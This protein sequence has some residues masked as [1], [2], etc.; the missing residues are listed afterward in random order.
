MSLTSWFLSIEDCQNTQLF[1][2]WITAP[3][4][5]RL[6]LNPASQEGKPYDWQPSRPAWSSIGSVLGETGHEAESV[7]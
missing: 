2:G 3:V 4:A 7:S 5:Q 1:T 6:T